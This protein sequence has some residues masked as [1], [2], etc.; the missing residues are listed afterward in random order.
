MPLDHY[1]P[2]GNRVGGILGI[3]WS[4]AKDKNQKIIPPKIDIKNCYSINKIF[5]H[6][7]QSNR[8]PEKKLE[9]NYSNT[10]TSKS[11]EVQTYIKDI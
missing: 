1:G 5:D 11:I 2:N 10:D 3:T 4:S 6:S 9:N 7:N 8:L